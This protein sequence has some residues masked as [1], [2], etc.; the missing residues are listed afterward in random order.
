MRR[1]PC[2]SAASW[3]TRH[4]FD[5]LDFRFDDRGSMFGGVCAAEVLLPE[6]GV[7]AIRTGQYVAVEG[8]YRHPWEGEIRPES[9]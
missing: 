4:G 3:L 8:G 6:Y 9:D 2:S 5:N 7:A 1:S